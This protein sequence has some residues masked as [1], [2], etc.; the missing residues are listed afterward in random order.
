MI[1]IV[2]GVGWVQNVIFLTFVCAKSVFLIGVWVYGEA[3]DCEFG[4]RT[5]FEGEF[6]WERANWGE[7]EG[8]LK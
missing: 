6:E 2:S 4:G 3:F 5:G 7:I 1:Y 8:L